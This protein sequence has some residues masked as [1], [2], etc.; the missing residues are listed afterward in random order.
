MV[1]MRESTLDLSLIDAIPN[2][3]NET[4]W[5]IWLSGPCHYWWLKEI[6]WW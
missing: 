4:R 5:E 3:S 1:E 2:Y 6:V